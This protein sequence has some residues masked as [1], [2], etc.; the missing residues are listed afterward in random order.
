MMSLSDLQFAAMICWLFAVCF[1]FDALFHLLRTLYI[2]VRCKMH[3]KPETLD[4]HEF[5]WFLI[6]ICTVM[7]LN[8]SK[9]EGFPLI[10]AVICMSGWLFIPFCVILQ[11]KLVSMKSWREYLE[12]I[13][14]R[15]LGIFEQS[16]RCL[17]WIEKWQKKCPP[18]IKL[19]LLICFLVFTYL[20]VSNGSQNLPLVYLA[21]VGWLFVFVFSGACAAMH[22]CR[23]L[24]KFWFL[25]GCLL[26]CVVIAFLPNLTG[27]LHPI[28]QYIVFVFIFL[29]IWILVAGAA[30]QYVAKM[31]ANIV[32]TG[33]TILVILINVLV[34]WGLNQLGG[35]ELSRMF[36]DKLQYFGN[37]ILL[38][39]IVS[40]YLSALLKEMQIYRC[41]RREEQEKQKNK[42]QDGEQLRHH[43]G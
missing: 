22:S 13:M 40:G 34:E 31:A 3:G 30:D 8:L 33:T 29:V 19:I 15:F 36:L 27:H 39:L 24:L 14:E 11:K 21:S 26:S 5:S 37:L 41:A 28:V 4:T 25:Q 10:P 23:K 12:G 9:A 6:I 2:L 43:C 1:A 17:L 16:R 7:F 32:N 20:V 18:V 38:P 42:D 35:L